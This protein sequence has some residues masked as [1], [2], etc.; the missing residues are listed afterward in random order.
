MTTV[1]QNN[2]GNSTLKSIVIGQRPKYKKVWFLKLLV[3]L[4]KVRVLALSEIRLYQSK[5]N[6]T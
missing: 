6:N 5:N 3:I 1:A 2:S 4:K